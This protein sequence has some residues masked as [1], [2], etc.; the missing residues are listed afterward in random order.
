MAE[1]Q[2]QAAAPRRP[3]HSKRSFGTKHAMPGQHPHHRALDSPAAYDASEEDND[4]LTDDG[5]SA[6]SI[7][8]SAPAPSHSRGPNAR[9]HSTVTAAGAARGTRP[10]HALAANVV[11]S[12]DGGI[13]TSAGLRALAPTSCVRVDAASSA[14]S[15]AAGRDC[16]QRRG[17]VW[18]YGAES[19]GDWDGGAEDWRVA[20]ERGQGGGRESV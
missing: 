12:D 15:F 5:A 3:L 16:W 10:R 19:G 13:D 7:H 2:T 14:P 9:A 18:V 11:S 20:V 6:I 8:V 4:P 1:T 17:E